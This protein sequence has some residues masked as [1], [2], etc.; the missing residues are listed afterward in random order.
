MGQ[1][2]R[3]VLTLWPEQTLKKKI[4]VFKYYGQDGGKSSP[5]LVTNASVVVEWRISCRWD[6]KAISTEWMCRYYSDIRHYRIK[7][8]LTL[9]G[10]AK[11]EV[12]YSCG[13]SVHFQLTFD[14]ARSDFLAA[15]PYKP[16]TNESN[17]GFKTMWEASFI[18]Q[19]LRPRG[20]N[21]RHSLDK[22]GWSGCG[23]EKK[24]TCL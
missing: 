8:T 19:T 16:Q 17:F 20:N 22:T 3:W 24:N 14:T 7:S 4:T 9:K 15:S 11:R 21:S 5:Q 13:Y 12:R 1:C 18:S 2:C 6:H 23:G 10:Y